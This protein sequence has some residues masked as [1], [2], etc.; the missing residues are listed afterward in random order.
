MLAAP[1]SGRYETIFGGPVEVCEITF[2]QL[3]FDPVQCKS[4]KPS[5]RFRQLMFPKL[6]EIF[7]DELLQMRA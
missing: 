3:F 5:D 4:S 6:G 1:C 2:S 7:A